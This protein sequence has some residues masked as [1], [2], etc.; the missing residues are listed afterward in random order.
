[1][2]GQRRQH[3]IEQ[4]LQKLEAEQQRILNFLLTIRQIAFIMLSGS[5]DAL[6]IPRSL[7]TKAQRR[8]H[9]E[10]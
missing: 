6:G 4:R 3:E 9:K 7:L 1:M 10:N 8:A 5:E 2:D